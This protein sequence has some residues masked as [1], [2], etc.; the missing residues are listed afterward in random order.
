MAAR[1]GMDSKLYETLGVPRTASDS[2]IKRAYHKL[3]KEFHPD[4]NP[5]AGD[6]FKEI[7]FAYDVL[8][9]QKKRDVYDR[10]GLKGLQEGAGGREDFFGGFGGFGGDIFSEFFGGAGMSFGGGGHSRTRKGEDTLK[11][12]KVTLEDL[13]NGKSFK[14]KHTRNAVCSVC[15]GSG[16]LTGKSPKPCQ[17]CRGAGIKM[18]YRQLGPGLVQ[19]IQTVCHKCSG[20]GNVISEKDKCKTCEGKKVAQESKEIE[21][22]VDKGMTHGMK[23]TMSGTGDEEPGVQAGDLIFVIQ[24]EQHALFERQGENLIMKRTLTLSESLC[25]FQ[26][27]IRHLD[28]RDLVITRAP[29]HVVPS[30]SVQ[31]VEGEGMPQYKRPFDKG[32]LLIKFKVDFPQNHFTDEKTLKMLE[33]LL[34]PRPEFEM[35]T[36]DHVEEV[37]L[38]DHHPSEYNATQ[39]S[40]D[41]DEPH[42]ARVGCAQQ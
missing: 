15:V 3:A 24:Q 26:F 18:Q 9:D 17:D 34:P 7:S 35:P 31:I 1:G 20:N 11:A 41:D 28:G 2:E 23:I 19:Q 25:G 16:T 32:H 12:L 10:Y 6:R 40:D 30:D 42:G 5:E 14:I 33:T 13:Y 36:G 38:N 29:G 8:S 21:V 4:K 27:V 39:E 22:H 37:D